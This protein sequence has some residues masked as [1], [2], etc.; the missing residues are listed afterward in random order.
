MAYWDVDVSAYLDDMLRQLDSSQD[1]QTLEWPL[2]QAV[3]LADLSGTASYS[4]GGIYSGNDEQGAM[5]QGVSMSFLLDLAAG[6]ISNGRLLVLDGSRE[7]W[8]AGFTGSV[9]GAVATMTRIEGTVGDARAITGGSVQGYFI[10]NPLQ[11]DFITGFQLQSGNDAVQGL[12]I[13]KQ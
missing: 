9:S 13:L 2:V 11:P 12:T 10:G 4:T 8:S 1:L 6:S 7:L 5:L 3:S